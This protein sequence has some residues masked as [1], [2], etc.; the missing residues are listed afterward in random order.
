MTGII[1]FF[2]STPVRCYCKKQAS[3]ES[4]TY[5]SEIVAD[6]IG[7]EIGIECRYSLHML[8]VPIKE[9]CLLGDNQGMIQDCSIMASQ[10]MKKHNAITYHRIREAVAGRIITLGYI[11]T[12]SNLSDILTKSYKGTIVLHHRFWGV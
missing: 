7:V 9:V 12:D 2:D 11:P 3:I 6:C 5:G 8:G 1:V 4:S 10:L